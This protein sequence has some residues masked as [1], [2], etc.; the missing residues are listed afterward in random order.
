MQKLYSLVAAFILSAVSAFAAT[1]TF[2]ININEGDVC[3]LSYY[4]NTTYS[5]VQTTLA[6][7]ENTFEVDTYSITLSLDSNSDYI[8]TSVLKDGNAQSISSAKSYYAYSFAGSTF[9]ITVKKQSEAY[10]A[11]CTIK[12]D[13]PSQVQIR[14]N[15]LSRTISL[16]ETETE[17]E[18][19]SS[20]E[21]PFTIGRTT[22]GQ[23]LYSI[24][25]NGESQT[26]SSYTSVP[27]K[28]GDVIEIEANFPEV[29]YPLTFKYGEGAEGFIT[30][31]TVNNA[32]VENF[33]EGVDVQ[34]GSSVY[35][36]GDT[37]NYKFESLTVGGNPVSYFY[38]SYSFTMNEA[39]EVVVNAHKYAD[40][41]YSVKV[42]DPSTIVLY[43]GYSYNGTII[44]LQAGSNDLQISENS[45]Y[46][47]FKAADGCYISS[48]TVNGE[49]KYQGYTETTI[50]VAEG[51]AIEVTSAKI[52][53]DQNLV[54]F[55]N[56]QLDP[57]TM[58]YFYLTFSDRN[59]IKTIN[60]GY[61]TLNFYS[62]DIPMYYSCYD[63]AYTSDE[64]YLNDE[65]VSPMY[66]GSTNRTIEGITNNSVLKI[67]YNESPETY[68]VTVESSS[69]LTVSATKDLVTEVANSSSFTVLGPS[70]VDLTV[71]GDV[72]EGKVILVK[73]NDEKVEAVDGVY[74]F[75]VNADTSVK[76]STT[77]GVSNISV[78]GNASSEVYNLQGI[79]VARSA[80]NL[81]S[82]PAGLYIVN[83]KK[84]VVK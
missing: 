6:A 66:S 49:E 10:D 54:V 2:T 28:N 41:S 35:I 29:Y 19:I 40:L 42:D 36:Y 4:D 76:V 3:S 71:S 68:N 30:S 11:K 48:I 74:T 15:V 23:N 27:V 16:T 26:V 37:Q 24:K 47:T 33:N 9:D 60:K 21:S 61:N 45:N 7:G 70:Q 17:V 46:I 81:N 22:Y 25:L 83:G 67:F 78:D 55:V 62:G 51:D 39:T 69:D 58:A 52:V 43:K 44:D 32:S 1:S 56:D 13:D 8:F 20:L 50:Y 18:F 31:V 84:V 82:L 63:G 65:V 53:R 34:I 57:Q 72:E 14:T 77:N 73:V 5:S 12:V 38:G 79:R 80:E 75:T 59:Q 64:V